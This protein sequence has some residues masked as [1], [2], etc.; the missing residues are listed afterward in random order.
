MVAASPILAR[1]YSPDDF[2][3]YAVFLAI[4]SIAAPVVSLRYEQAI[5]LAGNDVDAA[6]VT[7]VS[8]LATLLVSALL[9]V[10]LVL[11][12]S[13][14]AGILRTPA[15]IAV[16]PFLPIA[17]LLIGAFQILNAACLRVGAYGLIA[18]TRAVRATAIVGAQI[19][20]H[21][22]GGAGAIAGHLVGML[23]GI[24]SQ[25]RLLKR[26]LSMGAVSMPLMTK[27]AYDFRGLPLWSWG[28]LAASIGAHLPV[29]IFGLLF[30]IGFAGLFA[31]ATRV[32]A[33]P[34][35]VVGDAI[36]DVFFRDGAAAYREGR[37]GSL[38]TSIAIKLTLIAAV[39]TMILIVAAPWLF[40]IAF[41][42]EWIEAGTIARWLAPS[43]LVT[44]V[45]GPLSR[46]LVIT[47][48]FGRLTA[49]QLLN[50]VF[51]AGSIFLGYYISNGD[52]WI[53]LITFA[54]ASTFCYALML[55]VCLNA[56]RSA[57]SP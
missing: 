42:E 15:L 45:A 40:R 47:R 55:V 41:G 38:T 20:A 10:P 56:A 43:L 14:I 52:P 27:L 22:L 13:E 44:F 11:Y 28:P 4:L 19:A 18:Q 35:Q 31:M 30:S 6:N 9:A 25:L 33:A 57:P 54:V 50:G 32:L 3:I 36:A 49:L 21:G 1:L 16:L 24:A 17:L 26:S 46:V 2:G 12:A 48:Q 5:I 34:V 51:R 23:F 7:A 29:I 8:A 37:L 39:P 53:S